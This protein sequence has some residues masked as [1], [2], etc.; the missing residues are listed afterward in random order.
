M[1]PDQ[2]PGG[3]KHVDLVDLDQQHWF[4]LSLQRRVGVINFNILDIIL[5]FL[6]KNKFLAFFY[7]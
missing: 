5:N 1:D 7:F 2:D 6:E 3:P 4:Y